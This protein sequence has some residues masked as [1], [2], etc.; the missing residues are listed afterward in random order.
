MT[1]RVTSQGFWSPVWGRALILFIFNSLFFRK[2]AKWNGKVL[3]Y[4]K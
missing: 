2:E 1:I 4:A 3:Q